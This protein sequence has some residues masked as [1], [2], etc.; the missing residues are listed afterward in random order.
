[1]EV[2]EVALDDI[3]ESTPTTPVG[4]VIPDDVA[5]SIPPRSLGPIDP[6]DEDEP[7]W[8]MTI[9]SLPTW[10][11]MAYKAVEVAPRSMPGATNSTFVS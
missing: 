3:A 5:E 8:A 9:P 11:K 7:T 10:R 4:P 1:M 6:D 2:A